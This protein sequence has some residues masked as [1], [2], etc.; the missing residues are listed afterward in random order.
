MPSASNDSEASADP[1]ALPGAGTDISVAA[2]AGAADVLAADIATYRTAHELHFTR[3]DYAGALAAWN[4]YLARYPH[5]TFVP[6]ARLNRAVCLARLGK[7]AEARNLLSA[8][9]ASDDEYTRSRARKLSAALT[10]R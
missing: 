5:G 10:A 4:A 3:G 1:Q 8:L 7:T 2:K 9:G 6:E